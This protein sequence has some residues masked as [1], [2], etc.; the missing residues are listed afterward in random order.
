M[1]F[2]GSLNGPR[3]TSDWREFGTR[4]QLETAGIVS[5][6]QSKKVVYRGN[7]SGGALTCEELSFCVTGSVNDSSGSAV[8]RR[9]IMFKVDFELV[10]RPRPLGTI[11]GAAVVGVIVGSAL[12]RASP[13][14][15][16]VAR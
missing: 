3:F 11:L 16:D 10:Q 8:Q 13:I 1:S 12:Q 15:S 9:T 4:N 14:A 5:L 6:S 7:S 2:L